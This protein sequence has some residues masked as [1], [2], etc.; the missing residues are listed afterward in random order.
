M[1]NKEKGRYPTNVVLRMSSVS[2]IYG[3]CDKVP[4]SLRRWIMKFL[5]P[6]SENNLFQMLFG[7]QCAIQKYEIFVYF[8]S[9]RA[10]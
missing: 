7:P 2:Q 3:K 1:Q 4:C 10:K 8:Q 6:T 9:S 5:L